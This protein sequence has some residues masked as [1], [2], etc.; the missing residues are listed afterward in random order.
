MRPLAG[1]RHKIKLIFGSDQGRLLAAFIYLFDASSQAAS[2]RHGL[3]RTPARCL[4]TSG[5]IYL[6]IY[7]TIPW[8]VQALEHGCETA[9]SLHAC[10]HL[11]IYLFGANSQAASHRHGLWRTPARCLSTSGGIYLFIYLSIHGFVQSI[12]H[13]SSMYLFI[14]PF[15]HL[16]FNL[17][18]HLFIHTPI[19][20]IHHPFMDPP[21]Y[22]FTCFCI[23]LF[24]Y[25]FIYLFIY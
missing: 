7:R 8:G 12:N 6:F 4:S 16:F 15:I 18:I 3:Q 13:P 10:A 2:H 1:R 21:M 5:R 14:H 20:S 22:P 9:S 17:Y 24:I 25:A 19:Q 23:Y 11:F